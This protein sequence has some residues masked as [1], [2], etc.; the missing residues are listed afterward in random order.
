M[1]QDNRPSDAARKSAA[2]SLRQALG[3][4]NLELSQC[5]VKV[6]T[7]NLEPFDLRTGYWANPASVTSKPPR[8]LFWLERQDSLV[9]ASVP[10]APG[11]DRL[12][13]FNTAQGKVSAISVRVVPV[14]RMPTGSW[15]FHPAWEW[16][17][18]FVMPQ[19]LKP[20][21]SGQVVYNFR[22][23]EGRFGYLYN[24]DETDPVTGRP[25]QAYEEPAYVTAGLFSLLS[26]NDSFAV[27]QSVAITY[28]EATQALQRLINVSPLNA[29]TSA[30]PLLAAG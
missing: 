1:P 22:P 7:E 30:G 20:G 11:A 17:L 5:G 3:R 23:Q 27:E 25:K 9:V 16:M 18:F 21:S 10:Q 13:Y 15:T 2:A 24:T 29:G 6:Y 14:I 8:W 28:G 26:P 19:P 4:R 12:G